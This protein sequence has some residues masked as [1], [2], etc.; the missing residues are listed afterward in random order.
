MLKHNLLR[1]IGSSMRNIVT[2]PS[3]LTKISTTC[4]RSNEID[5]ATL[6]TLQRK[7]AGLNHILQGF[8]ADQKE[9]ILAIVNQD[10]TEQ[11]LSYDIAKTRAVK[12]LAWK[13]RNGSLKSI[14]DILLIEG[15]S[16]KT[17]EKFYKSMFEEK[18][19]GSKDKRTPRQ[20][21]A[22]FITPVIDVDQQ[23]R[24]RTC[25]SLRVGVSSVTWARLELAATNENMPG[26]LT[27]WHHHEITDKKLHLDD[28]IKRLLYVD[29]L[30]PNSDVY[31]FEEPPT[32]QINNNPGT[33]SQQN[34]NMQKCQI[35]AVLAFA[36]S[37]RS[38]FAREVAFENSTTNED[39]KKLTCKRPNVFY[40]RRFLPA[41]LFNKLVATERVSS[42]DT[43]LQLMHTHYNVE[44]FFEN[45]N[46]EKVE[47]VNDQQL[48]YRG[49]VQFS[50]EQRVM[51]SRAERYHREFLGQSLLLNLA[52]VRL[53]L[54]QD[55]RSIAA[56]TRQPKKVA[57]GS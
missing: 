12:L 47:S 41:R 6:D 50:Q 39:G 33:A 51:F 22:G 18:N 44:E 37:K 53:I 1:F 52:F 35:I 38:S 46:G 48:S 34:V 42:E 15:F 45:E 16:A 27:H 43:I 14:E 8:T 23:K 5:I 20:R 4:C 36:L 19:E 13:K 28:L 25:C 49:N 17:A 11:I 3:N 30:I 7:T 40:L 2:P 32:A 54:L 10:N 21:T 26:F 55:E 57:M 31:L 9:K 29:Y 24:I 56:V